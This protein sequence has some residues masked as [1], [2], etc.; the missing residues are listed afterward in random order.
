M[1]NIKWELEAMEKKHDYRVLRLEQNVGKMKKTMDDNTKI[2]TE[3]T[4]N[5]L[6]IIKRDMEELG[7]NL[8][9]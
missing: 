5:E 2:I 9:N 7:A 4:S 8:F 3:E 1:E 6:E